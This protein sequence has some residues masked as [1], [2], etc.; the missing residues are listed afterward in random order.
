MIITYMRV[1]FKS[2]YLKSIKWLNY[3]RKRIT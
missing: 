2:N 1:G 3:P